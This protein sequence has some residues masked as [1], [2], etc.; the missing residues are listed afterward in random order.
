MS[1]APKKEPSEGSLDDWYLKR[2]T[3]ADRLRRLGTRAPEGWER[4]NNTGPWLTSAQLAGFLS[5]KLV[6]CVLPEEPP[7]EPPK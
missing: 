7:E 5:G 1:E 6:G 2:S 4:V 3:R